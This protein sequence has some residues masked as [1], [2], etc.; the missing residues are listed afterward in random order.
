MPRRPDSHVV[1]DIALNRVKTICGDNGWACDVVHSDYGDDLLVQ[2]SHEDLVDHFKI[3]IQVKGTRDINRLRKKSGGYSIQVSLEHALK[4]A[5]SKDLVVVVLWDVERDLGYWTV[6]KACV[7]EWN[8]YTADSRTSSLHFSETAVF[9]AA[10][11]GFIC[12]LARIDHY[13]TL[14]NNAIVVDQERQI[15]RSLD[16]EFDSSHSSRVPL[17]GFDFLRVV[18]VTAQVLDETYLTYHRNAV[19]NIRREE[20]DKSDEEI[21]RMAATLALLGRVDDVAPGCGLPSPLMNVCVDVALALMRE[22]GALA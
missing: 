15:A 4:W 8:L 18:G 9:D 1:A 20:P 12:W 11:A 6:P 5:R 7:D 17:L 21:N 2:T 10:Q 13:A 3:W 16:V 22:E 14:V 19:A